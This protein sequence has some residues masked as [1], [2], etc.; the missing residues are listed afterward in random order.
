MRKK[1]SIFMLVSLEIH[2][3]H[4]NL[5][6]SIVQIPKLFTEAIQKIKEQP[7]TVSTSKNKVF[8]TYDVKQDTSI[9]FTIPYDKG[10][11]AY[12]DG[13]KIEIKQ[14][15]TGFMKVDV[16]KGKGTITFSFISN[17]FITGA[18]CSFT[19]LLLFGTYNHRRKSSKA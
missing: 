19:S 6:P 2:R 7:V 11:S 12:Q 16:P 9:F 17:G 4:L 8:A 5:L 14:A 10:W 18:I 3:Y 13:K 15:Q 1:L